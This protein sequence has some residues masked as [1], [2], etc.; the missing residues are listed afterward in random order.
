[1]DTI[2]HLLDSL[3]GEGLA[4]LIRTG[5]YLV[6]FLIV[7]AE[8]GLLI[9]FFLP[10]DSLLFTAGALIGAGM[11][12]APSPFP[13][14]P[15]LSL[16]LLWA[17]LGLAAVLGDAVGY[18]IGVRSGPL[19]Y[20]RPDSR[21]FKKEHLIRTREFYERH[22]P[23]TIILARWVPFAR[24]FA[25]VLAGVGKMPYGQFALYNVVGGL[26]W[27]I[28]CSALGF[29]LGQVE[30][31]RRHNE[32]VILLIVAFSLLP[33]VIHSVQERR[34]RTAATGQPNSTRR[35]PDPATETQESL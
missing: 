18:W 16:M 2:K 31:V 23:K 32:K 30:W 19:L 25:P 4:D 34:Q 28:S 14:D 3:H 8:T 9:G 20:Q 24:T 12:M 35:P 26:T 33:V 5:G 22:G 15:F 6:L 27:V 11:L 1:M 29:A 21:L 13:P 17:C 7:F 10:G